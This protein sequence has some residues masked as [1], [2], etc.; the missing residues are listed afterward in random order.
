MKKIIL[1]V[2]IA[3]SSTS[4]MAT[5]Y[6]IVPGDDVIKVVRFK[7]MTDRPNDICYDYASNATHVNGH[8]SSTQ[9]SHNASITLHISEGKT[10]Q[11]WEN[12]RCYK[13]TSEAYER[14]K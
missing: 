6:K 8:D 1:A 2:L 4:A 14:I 13:V 7:D 12:Y 9:I 3:A 11:V 10:Y 5:D